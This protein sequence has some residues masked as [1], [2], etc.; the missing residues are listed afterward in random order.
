LRSAFIAG[1]VKVFENV[2]GL[3]QKNYEVVSMS[4]HLNGMKSK[5]VFEFK[6]V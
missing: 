4:R 6:K 2:I 3:L 5:R 1:K